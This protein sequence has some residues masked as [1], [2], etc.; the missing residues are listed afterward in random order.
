VAR[1]AVTVGSAEKRARQT[2]WL[3]DSKSRLRSFPEGVKDD[4][5]AAI[6]WAQLGDKHPDAKP[7]SGFGG[8]GVLEVVE[9]HDGD[10]YRAVYTVRFKEWIYILHCFQKKSK[11]GNETP[12]HDMNLIRVRLKQAEKLEAAET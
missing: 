9:N 3:G 11:K 10:T 4:I 12:R 8:A 7:L 6:M 2:R 1:G 5:G